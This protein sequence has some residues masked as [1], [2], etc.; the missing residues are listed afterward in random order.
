MIAWLPTARPEVV[1]VAVPVVFRVS[2]SICVV[3]SKNSTVPVGVAVPLVGATVAVKVTA[4]PYVDGP[5]LEASAVVVLVGLTTCA[6][7][8]EGLPASV[9]SP[10]YWALIAWLPAARLEVVNVAVSV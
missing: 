9:A 7:V 5:G 6:S 2:M 4:C 1:N 3:P 8:A 10:R